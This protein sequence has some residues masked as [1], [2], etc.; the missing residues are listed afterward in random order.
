MG[1]ELESR[2]L[3]PRC[4]SPNVRKSRY[5]GWERMWVLVLRRPYRCRWC[6]AR[7]VRPFFWMGG[8]H[9]R[10][11]PTLTVDHL[12]RTPFPD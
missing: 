7:F 4:Q 10:P 8:R 11:A 5:R 3:C 6:L 1:A 2:T 9:D 12:L